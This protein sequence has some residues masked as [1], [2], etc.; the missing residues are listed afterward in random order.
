MPAIQDPKPDR[1][2]T[3]ARRLGAGG[4]AQRTGRLPPAPEQELIMSKE[5]LTI[6]FVGATGSVGRLAIT[7]ALRQGHTARALVRNERRART[8]DHRL[9]SAWF[10]QGAALKQRALDKALQLVD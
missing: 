9:D 8:Q 7:E 6:V 3:V 4:A 1:Q 5:P 2:R 10:G